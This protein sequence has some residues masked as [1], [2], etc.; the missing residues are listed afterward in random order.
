M[1]R[2]SSG[3]NGRIVLNI[4]DADYYLIKCSLES[5]RSLRVTEDEGSIENSA[6]EML[7]SLCDQEKMIPELV[8][9]EG[10]DDISKGGD[11]VKKEILQL[12]PVTLFPDKYFAQEIKFSIHHK[13]AKYRTDIIF[14]PV[15]GWAVI[16]ETIGDTIK[17]S[18]KAVV[19]DEFKELY[20]TTSPY[21]KEMDKATAAK[22]DNTRR[23]KKLLDA[24][25]DQ[26]GKVQLYESMMTV[27]KTET[28][29]VLIL[30][31]NDDE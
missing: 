20:V 22:E 10:E 21:C 12:Y 19:Y 24:I 23:A 6:G 2:L 25:L 26:D 4:S 9:Y 5:L 15:E 14:V 8:G 7:A 16:R 11:R 13:L 17:L 30:S 27:R 18:I 29:D 1:I 31:E 3:N 28:K